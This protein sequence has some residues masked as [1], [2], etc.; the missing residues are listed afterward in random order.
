MRMVLFLRY[1]RR[2]RSQSQNLC[3]K[4]SRLASPMLLTLFVLMVS[5]VE[6]TESRFFVKTLPGLVGDLPFTLETG[7]IGVGESEDVQLF[8]Y[9]I[10]SEGNP[11]DDPLMLWLT[12]GPSCSALS[13]LLYEIGPF[14]INDVKSKFENKPILELNTHSWTKAANIIFLDQPVGSGFSYA[15]TPEAYLTNDTSTAMDVYNFLRTWLVDHPKFVNSPLYIG[16]NEVGEGPRMNIKGYLLGNPL[17]DRSGD[18]N[19]RI[20]FA[21]SKALLSD[22]I[23]KSCNDNCHGDYLNVEPNNSLCVHDLQV[24]AKCLDGIFIGNIEDTYSYSAIW[25]NRRDVRK[26]L[27][28]HEEFE[29]IEWVRCNDSMTFDFDKKDLSYTHNVVSSVNYHQRLADKHCRAL[30]YSGD[31][32]MMIP[33]LG[34]LKW[35]GSLNLSIKTDWRPWFVDKQVAGYTLKYSKNNYNLTFATVKGG[36]HTAPEYKPKECLSMFKHYLCHSPMVLERLGKRSMLLTTKLTTKLP[37]LLKGKPPDPIIEEFCTLT[38]M[39]VEGLVQKPFVPSDGNKPSKPRGRPKGVKNKV[40]DIKIK[41]QSPGSTS[42]G[43]GAILKRLRNLKMVGKDRS[44]SESSPMI[45]NGKRPNSSKSPVNDV[46]NPL[47]ISKTVVNDHSN[48]EFKDGDGIGFVDPC[49]VSNGISKLDM[50]DVE[51]IE[52]E[53]TRKANKDGLDC[54]SN[55]SAFMFGKV[56]SNKGILKKPLSDGSLNIE[57]FA[58]KMKKGV[59]DRELLRIL[60]LNV[61]LRVVMVLEEY[62]SLWKILRRE[63]KHVHCN[64]MAILWEPLSIIECGVGKTML[65]DKLTKERCLKKPGKLDFARV[66]VEVLAVYELPCSLEIKYPPFGNRPARGDDIEGYNNHFHELALMCPDLASNEKKKTKRYIRGLPERIKGNITFLKPTTLYDAINMARE[67]V[68]QAVQGKAARV[69]ERNKRKQKAARVY[70]AAPTVRRN[71]AGNAPYCN[72]CRLHH[73]GADVNSLQDVTCYGCGEKGHP[74]NKCPK[75][76]NQQNDGAR[77]EKSFVSTVFTP[78]INIAPATLDTSYEVEL[79]DGKVVSTNTVL[80]G[81]TLALYNLFFKIDLLPTRLGSFIVIVGL[82]SVREIEFRIDLILGA[83]PVGFIRPSHSP[84][85]AHVL[86]FEKKDGAMRTCIDYKELNKLTIINRYPLLRIDDLFDQLQGTSCFSKIDLRLGYHQLR[87]REE[88]IPNTAFRTCYGHFEFMV[89]PFM[90]T[91]T[92]AIF[93]NLMNRVC[94]PYLDKF[95]IVFIDDI[96]I[97]SKSEEEHEVHLKTILDLLKKEKLYAKFSKCEF[98]LKEV[99]FLGHAVNQNGIHVDPSK[100]E[101]V[102]NWKT[103]EPPLEIRS[104]LGLMGYYQRFIENF[105]KI[106]KPFTLLTQR[107]KT[108]VWGNKQEEA[109]RILKEKLCKALVLALLDGPNDFVVYCDASNQGQDN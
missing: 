19:S 88:D 82:P 71:Y 108:Y 36:G 33:Y 29:D 81:C 104:F 91:N 75:G 1:T 79:A 73:Y 96:L 68:E 37:L 58:E 22:E 64:S 78:F 59:E 76:R 52:V 39:E 63:V 97:Y 43:A 50:A 7:Y 93:M 60:L 99:Q 54:G 15:K 9:F 6:V 90:L 65:M 69:S 23:Y 17:T 105:S 14:T 26:A 25:A 87:V 98:W 53:S 10:E 12:G 11:K 45:S 72:K 20:P 109:F 95:I 42:V 51:H 94:K 77:A 27:H 35:I 67:L 4:F 8:Y 70:V 49:V 107:N 16:G 13:G 40:G 101:L 92:P 84:W 18:Y 5:S 85:G 86:F 34:T 74:K 38:G 103:L 41:V 44:R 66:L 89:M 47:E 31:H 61:F 28:I 83:L 48:M 80:R 3:N 2:Q 62:L 57:S 56:Q 102:K 55:D 21:H 24:V 32:D 100:V 46:L 30:V 106:A